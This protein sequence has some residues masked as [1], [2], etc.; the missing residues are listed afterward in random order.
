MIDL[1]WSMTGL[2]LMLSYIE[3]SQTQ[4]FISILHWDISNT[5]L[6]SLILFMIRK[7]LKLRIDQIG[8][9]ALYK[10]N[11]IILTE[12]SMILTAYSNAPI[13]VSALCIIVYEIEID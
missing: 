2:H 1:G 12:Q 6:Q 8:Y 9:F 3:I 7:S 10:K 13:E 11:N 5:S 4:V